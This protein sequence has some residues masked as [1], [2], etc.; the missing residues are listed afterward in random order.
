MNI[1]IDGEGLL[2]C[3]EVEHGLGLENGC[4]RECYQWKRLAVI[5]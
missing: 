1:H 4:L 3:S 2:T 5:L